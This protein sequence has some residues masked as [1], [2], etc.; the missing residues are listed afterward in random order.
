MKKLLAS[1]A[2][3]A[4]VAIPVGAQEESSS[5]SSSASSSASSGSSRSARL[6]RV[7][8]S[9]PLPRWAGAGDFRGD[10]RREVLRLQARLGR[11]GRQ[12]VYLS[13]KHSKQPG[14]V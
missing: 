1:L 13:S 11:V 8:V 12:A 3:T 2:I 4:L 5:S 9:Q 14:K 7:A 10:D 6:D